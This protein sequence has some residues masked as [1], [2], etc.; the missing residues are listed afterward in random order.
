[1]RVRASV[2][3][4]YQ[5]TNGMIPISIY[6]TVVSNLAYALRAATSTEPQFESVVG[7]GDKPGYVRAK[8]LLEAPSEREAQ[9]AIASQVDVAMAR[10]CLHPPDWTALFELHDAPHGRSGTIRSARSG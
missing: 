9:A 10:A 3:A 4:V 8:Y 2:R 7:T 6:P 5:G 1:M